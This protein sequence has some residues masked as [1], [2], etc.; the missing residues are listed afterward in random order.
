MLSR[1]QKHNAP[2]LRQAQGSTDVQRTK[3]G[4][5][6]EDV[7]LKFLDQPAKQRVNFLQRQAWRFSYPLGF[8]SECAIVKRFAT[9]A[10]ALDHSVSCWSDRRRVD[11]QDSD[12]AG[13]NAIGLAHRFTVYGEG[14]S[15]ASPFALWLGVQ[16]QTARS[17][18]S[19]LRADDP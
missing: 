15:V 14:F 13:V 4:F 16:S 1:R 8:Y 17:L 19:T 9:A 11:S 18:A 12:A 5:H 3:N 10:V 7:G 6:R 2:Y